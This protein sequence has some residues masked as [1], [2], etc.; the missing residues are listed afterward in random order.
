MPRG[1]RRR[2]AIHAIARE[3]GVPCT[4]LMNWKRDG[5]FQVDE[6]GRALLADVRAA[7]RWRRTGATAKEAA[8]LLRMTRT[9]VNKLSDEGVLPT[10]RF[11]RTRL[12]NRVE[13]ERFRARRAE[14]AANWISFKAAWREYGI[15]YH[16]LVKLEEQGRLD[17]LLGRDHPELTERKTS[18]LV[19]RAQLE[20]VLAQLQENPDLCP[21]CENPVAPGR[22]WHATCIGPEAARSYWQGADPALRR[23]R[24]AAA[25][26]HFSAWWSSPAGLARRAEQRSSR[27]ERVPGKCLACRAPTERLPSQATRADREG[28]REF[29]TTC[30]QH[31]RRA[32]LATLAAVESA[33]PTGPMEPKAEAF[34][35]LLLIGQGFA[36]SVRETAQPRRGQPPN[37]AEFIVVEA[38]YK[39]GFTDPQIAELHEAV[40]GGPWR[41][42]YVTLVRQRT[43]VRRAA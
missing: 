1:E 29:C 13:L 15:P 19:E 12:I 2:L 7:V 26:A 9:T 23:E 39:R 24:I 34:E 33:N 14:I 43:G 8:V 32:R 10:K 27:V 22:V 18:Q 20:R 38:L 16:A 11:G 28:W 40:I 5:V 25:A 37:L 3:L 6:C 36:Q 31:Y 17:V 35:R 21:G 30:V 41:T 42:K 4:T